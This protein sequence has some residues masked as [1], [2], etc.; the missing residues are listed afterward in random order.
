VSFII[1]GA[2]LFFTALG[3]GEIA[4]LQGTKHLKEL[5][6]TSLI[7]SSVGLVVGVPMYFFWGTHGIAPAMISLALATYISNRFF[8]R[9]IKLVPINV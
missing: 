9:K 3:S 6:K 7:G 2:M 5:A 1:L 8:T 4:L